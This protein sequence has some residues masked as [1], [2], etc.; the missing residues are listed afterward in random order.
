[1]KTIEEAIHELL[2]KGRPL[3]CIVEDLAEAFFL[4]EVQARNL[5]QTVL[6]ERAL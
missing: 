5:I 3:C 1:M 6:F 2:G 4:P